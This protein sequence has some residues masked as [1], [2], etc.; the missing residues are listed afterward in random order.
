MIFMHAYLAS[1]LKVWGGG[2][3]KRR[4]YEY[5]VHILYHNI[6]M[7]HDKI[8]MQALYNSIFLGII[9]MLQVV[10]TSQSDLHQILSNLC[11]RHYEL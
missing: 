8:S 6:L 7:S 3:G 4:L 2:E 9:I 11:T 10:A 5:C 1:Y